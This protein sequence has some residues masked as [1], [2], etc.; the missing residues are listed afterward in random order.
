[1]GDLLLSEITPDHML[2]FREWWLDR[3]R[4]GEVTASSA[5]KDFIHLSA[6]LRSVDKAK[7]LGLKM[8]LSG[9]TV[10]GEGRGERPAFTTEWIRDRIL[11]PGA[12]AGM[13]TEARCLI[14]GMVNTGYRPS[15]AEQM[16]AA[17]IRL[18]ANI[19]H[20]SIEP[21]GRTLKSRNARR[22]IPL[23]GVSLEAFRQCPEGFPRYRSGSG[24]SNVANKF[25]R[26][27]GLLPTDRHSLYSLRHSFQ[28]RMIAAGI[29]DRI[30]RDIFGHALTEERYGSGAS[31]A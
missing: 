9:R 10:Q 3:I 21:V 13:N 12:L 31:L 19:P 14:L 24:V 8:P 17:Q 27:N 4:A 18:D 26:A 6:V 15:E 1:M 25:M 23:I 7:R 29:D 2:D 11:A 20:I 22:L 16:T 28:D 5:N 30:R